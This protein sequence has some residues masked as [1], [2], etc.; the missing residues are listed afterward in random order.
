MVLLSVNELLKS[1]KNETYIRNN[2]MKEQIQ[3]F[4]KEQSQ[5]YSNVLNIVI[6]GSQHID[7]SKVVDMDNIKYKF[8]NLPERFL[9]TLPDVYKKKFQLDTECEKVMKYTH[10]GNL[11]EADI[12]EA[13]CFY[14]L[15]K[16]L[17]DYVNCAKEF[18]SNE[19]SYFVS[20]S[21]TDFLATQIIHK[22]KNTPGLLKKLVD[23]FFV[24][25]PDIEPMEQSFYDNCY[26]R[27]GDWLDEQY[28]EI[29]NYDAVPQLFQK[30][31]KNTFLS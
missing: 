7:V 2:T 25:H 29:K 31:V 3:Q 18:F 10:K 24:R 26:C 5:L 21:V 28:L 9:A 23:S 19:N 8:M 27:V 13:L 15:R 22:V 6:T 4:L 16:V 11:A 30:I 12:E 20:Q 17:L 1:K 14:M